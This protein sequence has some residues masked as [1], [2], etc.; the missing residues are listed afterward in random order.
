MRYRDAL[1]AQEHR[2]EQLGLITRA[3]IGEHRDDSVAWPQCTC[4]ADCPGHIDA[5]GA[6]DAPAF[7]MQ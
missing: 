4:E 7:L 5:T 3:G 2:I 1:L 6:A